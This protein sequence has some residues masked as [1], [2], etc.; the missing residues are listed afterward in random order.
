MEDPWF[1]LS[2]SFD[3]RN[4]QTARG[5]SNS[6]EQ[7]ARLAGLGR[8]F[9]RLPTTCRPDGVLGSPKVVSQ[10][11]L[12]PAV[13]AERLLGWKASAVREAMALARRQPN[14][15]RPAKD[16]LRTDADLGVSGSRAPVAA[17]ENVASE[18]LEEGAPPR[19][20]RTRSSGSQSVM[21]RQVH[22]YSG[23]RSRGRHCRPW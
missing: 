11:H 6:G 13:H 17:T 14:G 12:A 10:R 22:G 19:G 23:L 2:T 3:N 15:P 21:R 5:A 4:S 9:G 1:V 20:A 7:P 16:R 8:G 18:G